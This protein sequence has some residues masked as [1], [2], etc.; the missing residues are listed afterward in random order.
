MR[1]VA[2]CNRRPPITSVANLLASACSDTDYIGYKCMYCD[3]TSNPEELHHEIKV[4][5]AKTLSIYIRGQILAVGKMS[6]KR[7]L[8]L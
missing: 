4:E 5:A 3:M 1:H 6:G 8:T 7:R 2:D